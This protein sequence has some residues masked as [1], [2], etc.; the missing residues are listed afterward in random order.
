VVEIRVR[1]DKEALGMVVDMLLQLHWWWCSGFVVL[2]FSSQFTVSES[3]YPLSHYPIL[4]VMWDLLINIIAPP[5][6]FGNQIKL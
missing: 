5:F 3:I 4:I 6:L 2:T 1:G